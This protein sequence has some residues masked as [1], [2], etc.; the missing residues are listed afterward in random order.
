MGDGNSRAQAV[1]V[2]E[3]RSS[4]S[5]AAAAVDSA[6]SGAQYLMGLQ[7]FTKLATFSANAIIAYLAGKDAFGVASVKFELL[8]ST[9]IFLSRE[10]MRNA[11]LR[12]DSIEDSGAIEADQRV[13][14]E[15]SAEQRPSK[16]DQVIINAS[17][18]PIAAGMVMAGL[19]YLI[20]GHG[21]STADGSDAGSD[22]LPYYSLSLTVYIIAA[23]VELCVEPLYV[24]SRARIMFKMQA[25]CEAISVTGRCAATVAAL[26]VGRYL[27]PDSKVNPFSLIAFAIGQLCYAVLILLTYTWCMS[28]ELKWSIWSCYTPHP[29][30]LND[31]TGTPQSSYI[32]S[33]IGGLAVT[34]IGQSLLKHLL[35]QGDNMVMS[36]FAK[37]SEMGTFA[38]VTVYGSIPARVIFL[39]LEEASRAMFS[40]MASKHIAET[41]EHNSSKENGDSAFQCLLGSVLIVFGTLYAPILLSFISRNSTSDEANLLI[42][43]CFYLPLM[44]LNGFLEAFVHSVAAKSQ[45]VRLNTAMVAFTAAYAVFAVQMLHT[46][47]LGSLGIILANMLNM[48]LRI[49]YCKRFIT[50]WF[51]KCHTNGPQLSAVLPHPAVL[52]ACVLSA[53]VVV[54]AKLVVG[55]ESVAQRLGILLIGG[56]TGVAV[57][58]TIWRYEQPFIQAILKLRSGKGQKSKIE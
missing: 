27:S 11:L 3:S 36:K 9:I 54:L 32:G 24:L 18:A 2:H 10:G 16:R 5:A 26:F 31:A 55:H 44:G 50:Q 51:A 25:Q 39:P 52:G 15:P 8:L 12:A 42:A 38:L 23:W 13:Q 48:A 30:A 43:Y 49:G 14:R 37:E 58:A 17:L 56:T 29:V 4:N 57:L 53:A 28:Q 19:A 34:F 21:A 40:K 35:T 20:Y 45:L 7:L 46:L 41:P 33:A 6:F 1:P 47:K 22:N